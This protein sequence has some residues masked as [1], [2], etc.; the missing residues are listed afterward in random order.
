M[1]VEAWQ[2]EQEVE[3]SYLQKQTQ[4][5]ESKVELGQGYKL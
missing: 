5:R 1:V 2:Q 4:S 3:R